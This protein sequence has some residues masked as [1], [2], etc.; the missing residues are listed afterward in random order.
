MLDRKDVK[1]MIRALKQGDII[2]YAPDHDYGP[3]SSVFV[4]LFAVDKAATTTGS[5]VLVR[6]EQTGDHSVHPAPP[7][8]RQRV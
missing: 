7:A 2:W 3:R 5:Y 8:G 1:G 4:P 6:M